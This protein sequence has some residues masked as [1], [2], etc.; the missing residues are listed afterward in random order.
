MPVERVKVYEDDQAIVWEET[1]DGWIGISVNPK[2]GSPAANEQ[3]VRERATRA[4]TTN[5]AFL[6]LPDYPASPTTAQRDQA[7]R[8]LIAQDRALTRQVNAIIRL[9]TQVF[10]DISDT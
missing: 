8:A 9:L 3:T 1:G 4:L 10:D 5:Q 2:P 7:I 6:D